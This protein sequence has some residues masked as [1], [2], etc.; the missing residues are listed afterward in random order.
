MHHSSIESILLF[1]FESVF[2]NNENTLL[3]V[4]THL[5]WALRSK[6]DQMI[7]VQSNMHKPNFI[8]MFFIW[9]KFNI[10]FKLRK[11]LIILKEWFE[12]KSIKTFT[13]IK[14]FPKVITFFCI[15]SVL[16][17]FNRYFCWFK[18]NFVAENRKAHEAKLMTT[19]IRIF[20]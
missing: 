17:H 3:F 7:N 9:T 2:I 10:K 5:K 18:V 15:N 14:F 1:I 16:R 11:F 4:K 6:K 13:T 19:I 12:I 8:I 20:N